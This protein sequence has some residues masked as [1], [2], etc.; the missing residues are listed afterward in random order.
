MIQPLNYFQL[1]VQRGEY[2]KV[3]ITLYLNVPN[4]TKLYLTVAKYTNCTHGT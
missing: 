1:D 3:K 2:S 4:Y